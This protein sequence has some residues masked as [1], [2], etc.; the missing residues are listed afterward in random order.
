MTYM[1]T[2]PETKK[3]YKYA[4]VPLTPAIAQ[5]LIIELFGNRLE[6]RQSIIDEVTRTHLAR[7]GTKPRAVDVPR[8]VKNA[9]GKLA[10]KG[11]AENRAY[12]QWYIKSTGEPG[13]VAEIGPSAASEQ[14]PKNEGTAS[15]PIADRVLELHPDSKGAVYVY[16]LPTFQRKAELD[17]QSVWHCKIG[18]TERDPLSRILEQVATALPEK[19]HISLVAYTREPAALES[20]I[21]GTLTVRGRRVDESPGREWFLTSPAEIEEIITFVARNNKASAAVA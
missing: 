19:P 8:M 5:E 18:R 1:S 14:D 21:Q 11:K 3:S 12:G 9:L 4:G 13:Q 2:D 15:M 20:A 16:H 10:N 17:G 7:G 6:T